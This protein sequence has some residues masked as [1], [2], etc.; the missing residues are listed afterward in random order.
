M[1][2]GQD[3][4]VGAVNMSSAQTHLQRSGA[5]SLTAFSVLNL[6]GGG[7]VGSSTSSAPGVEG[8]SDTGAGIRGASNSG[9]GVAGVSNGGVG[10]QGLSTDGDGVVGITQVGCSGPTLGAGVRGIDAGG[11]GVGVWASR[12]A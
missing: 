8:A 10:V 1:A 6:N 12:L 2:D 9:E 11:N 7:I 5:G 4:V 3:L